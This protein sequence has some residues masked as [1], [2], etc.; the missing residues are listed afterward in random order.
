MWGLDAHLHRQYKGLQISICNPLLL[1]LLF[2]QR[3]QGQNDYRGTF[4]IR[5]SHELTSHYQ[6]HMNKK[7]RD[8]HRKA[9]CSLSV[10]S[11]GRNGPLG[12]FTAAALSGF[13]LAAT[14][15]SSFVSGYSPACS[16]KAGLGGALCFCRDTSRNSFCGS[17]FGATNFLCRA[18]H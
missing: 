16:C 14:N 3:L 10:S 8:L 13:S 5:K 17:F 11:P 15:A 7:P 6:C 12:L 2:P 18:S 1:L 9:F 4:M